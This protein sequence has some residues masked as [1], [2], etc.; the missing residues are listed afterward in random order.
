MDQVYNV[1]ET[2]LETLAA[3]FKKFY[4]GS[5]CRNRLT[6]HVTIMVRTSHKC[7]QF[8]NKHINVF[9]LYITVGIS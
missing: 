2:V 8:V 4:W 3:C 6:I 5:K 1:D 9:K 7:K